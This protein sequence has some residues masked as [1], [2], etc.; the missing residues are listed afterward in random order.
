MESISDMK[1]EARRILKDRWSEVVLMNLIPTLILVFL[2][3]LLFLPLIIAAFVLF[4]RNGDIGG[5]FDKVSVT[6]NSDTSDWSSRFGGFFMVFINYGLSW[7][8]LDLV[9]GNIDGKINPWQ[10]NLR[11]FQ[12]GRG[13]ITLGVAFFTTLFI[14]FWSMLFLVP[15][16]IK[17]YSYAQAGYLVNDIDEVDQLSVF[18]YITESRRLMDGHKMDLFL[19]E[20]SFIGWH[21]LGVLSFGLGY[22]WIKPYIATTEAVFYNKLKG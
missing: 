19:L 10:A 9:R 13:W 5:V 6:I 20:L 4:I 7:T 12:S 2:L 14:G 1:L 3:S 16:I 21:I 18:D 22:L 11:V 17:T 15:G 8:Y